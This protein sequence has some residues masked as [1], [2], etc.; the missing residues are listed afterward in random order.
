MTSVLAGT[1]L[2]DQEV[3]EIHAQLAGIY[4]IKRVL[5][6]DE[7]REAA[8]L[9]GLGDGGKGESGFSGAFRAVNLDDTATGEAADA[10]GAVDENVARRDRI[11]RRNGGV[12]QATNGFAAIVL[13]DLLEGE[14]E[15]LI[16]LGDCLLV[17]SSG[18]RF[19][20]LG[21]IGV[22]LSLIPGMTRSRLQRRAIFSNP[23]A[24][25]M[26][27]GYGRTEGA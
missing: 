26:L 20:V 5:D 6:V 15:A 2:G 13:L 11:H 17:E 7:S 25:L 22:R 16:A 1:R 12:S 19:F 10:E 21:H 23:A 9:L 18:G 3:V 14:I 4:G 27:A 24:F 8:T